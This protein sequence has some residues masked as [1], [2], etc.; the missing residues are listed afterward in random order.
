[1][2]TLSTR[3]WNPLGFFN[4][5]FENLFTPYYEK[6]DFMKTDIIERD[7]EFLALLGLTP[8]ELFAKGESFR[9]SHIGKI[10][11]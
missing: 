10:L 5:T 1:M 9:I 3:T 11:K 7:E 2:R 4:D 6:F 8:D